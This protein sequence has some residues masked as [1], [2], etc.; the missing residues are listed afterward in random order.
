MCFDASS[1]RFWAYSGLLVTEVEVTGE[2]QHI[3]RLRSQSLITLFPPILFLSPSTLNP[4]LDAIPSR[5]DAT[6]R[7]F[8][9]LAAQTLNPT[10]GAISPLIVT[11]HWM[12]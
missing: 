9:T 5:D 8:Q 10:S 7:C 12:F 2:D 4:T 3:W 11:A 6:H 1:G